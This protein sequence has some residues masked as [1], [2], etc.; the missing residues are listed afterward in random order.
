MYKEPKTFHIDYILILFSKISL[1][2]HLLAIMAINS[3]IIAYGNR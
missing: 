2:E 3:C 1:Y